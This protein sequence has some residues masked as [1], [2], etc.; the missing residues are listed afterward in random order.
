MKYSRINWFQIE[1]F[2]LKKNC[3]QKIRN[4]KF[5]EPQTTLWKMYSQKYPVKKNQFTKYQ[6]ID[7]MDEI[8]RFGLSGKRF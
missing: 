6:N 1:Y 3:K 5:T 7:E 8:D 2:C 4:V